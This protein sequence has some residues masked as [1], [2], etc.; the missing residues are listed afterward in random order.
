[1]WE[2]TWKPRNSPFDSSVKMIGL[3]ESAAKV[4]GKS[5]RGS[6]SQ[7]PRSLEEAFGRTTE[8]NGEVG[9]GEAARDPGSPFGTKSFPLEDEIKELS[10]SFSYAFS[11][12][13]L[14][15]TPFDFPSL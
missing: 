9:G 2:P 3:R 8:N 12:S 14:N 15:A 5:E 13:I 1:M 11:K 6:P 10:V 7:T 4:K